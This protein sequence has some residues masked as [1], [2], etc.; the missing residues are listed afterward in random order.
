[1][2]FILSFVHFDDLC[3]SSACLACL[4]SSLGCQ[5]LG[6]GKKWAC[7]NKV[8]EKKKVYGC[9]VGS[10]TWVVQRGKKGGPKSRRM[11]IRMGSRTRDG[12]PVSPDLTS[13]HPLS[14][15]II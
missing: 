8:G 10:M 11:R 5:Y 9:F 4:Q 3:S 15:G 13:F 14:L 12:N 6:M 7:G 1:M 2:T